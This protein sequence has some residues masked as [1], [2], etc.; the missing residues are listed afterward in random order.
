MPLYDFD[1]ECGETL[2]K[3]VLFKESENVKCPVCGNIMKRLFSTQVGVIGCNRWVDK[4]GMDAQ[5]SKLRAAKSLEKR[6]YMRLHPGG[7]L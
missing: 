2:E 4:P 6:K 3:H 5:Q 1:C 7:I